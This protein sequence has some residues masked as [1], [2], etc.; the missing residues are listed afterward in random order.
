MGLLSRPFAAIYDKLMGGSERRW[1]GDAR[2]QLLVGLQGYVLEVGAG[3]GAN[4]P[5]YPPQATVVATEPSQHMLRRAAEKAA[6]AQAHIETKLADAQDL[7]FP[8]RTF[9]AV[10]ATLVFCTVPDPLKALNEARRVAK[11]GA[12]VLMIE[13]VHAETPVKRLLLSAWT[14]AQQVIGQGC[15][16]NRET[17]KS[18]T[19]AGL[20]LEEVRTLTTEMGLVPFVQIL[21][22]APEE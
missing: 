14:P 3:T 12:P 21:A 20:H 10:V 22:R 2:R 15:H 11:P 7:P 13:H 17:P 16:L 5:F 19:S 6:A 4:F 1:L 18:V 8:D 9:D